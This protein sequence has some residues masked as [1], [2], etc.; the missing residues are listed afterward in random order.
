MPPPMISRSATSSRA[1]MTPS[2]SLTLAPPRIT[3][4][5]PLGI[6]A[7]RQQDLDLTGQ[8]PAGGAGQEPR[9]ARRS[10]RG[11]G[12]TRRTRRSRR[13]PGPSISCCTNAGSLAV[14]PGS[15][16]RFSSSSTPGASSARRARTGSTEYFGSGAP[17][18]RPRWV[19]AVTCGPVLAAA[20]RWWAARRGCAGRR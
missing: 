17:L 1:S 19:H 7:Q 15:K 12:A 8:Q 4:N 2:L 18:G 14:S 16:R 9:R 20:T 3:T 10:R 13:G 6:G 5:G 11:P